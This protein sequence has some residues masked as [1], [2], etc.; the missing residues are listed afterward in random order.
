MTH[1]RSIRHQRTPVLLTVRASLD[2]L[3][4]LSQLLRLQRLG[5][6]RPVVDQALR[7]RA[8]EAMDPVAQIC[9]SIPPIFATDPRSIPSLPQPAQKPSALVD[10]LHR[11]PTPEAPPPNSLLAIYRYSIAQILH[12]VLN[13]HPPSIP[14]IIASCPE[15]TRPRQTAA[16]VLPGGWKWRA[17]RRSHRRGR[18]WRNPAPSQEAKTSRKRG[19]SYVQVQVTA[20]RQSVSRKR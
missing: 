5:T 8:V 12:T 17:W 9:R 1:L 20:D 7:T 10:V 3:R 19:N 6:L 11:R 15:A 13:Q 16:A 2:D 14:T 18:S 4:E